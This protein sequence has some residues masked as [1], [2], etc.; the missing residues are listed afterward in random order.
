MGLRAD[1]HFC[2]NCGATLEDQPGFD[3]AEGLWR[4]TS[5]GQELYGDDFPEGTRFP[6]TIWRCDNCRAVLNT[7]YGFDDEEDEWECTECGHVNHLSEDEIYESEEDWEAHRRAERIGSFVG[8]MFS[9][10]VAGSSS[11]RDDASDDED[12][13]DDE[14][15]EDEDDEYDEDNDYGSYESAGNG[16]EDYSRY[17]SGSGDGRTTLSYLSRW[18]RLKLY[19]RIG[20]ACLSVLIAGLVFFGVTRAIPL[21]ISSEAA[22]G[23]QY[24]ELTDVLKM[25]GF[26]QVEAV[27][28]DDLSFEHLNE[29]G[30]VARVQLLWG[31]SFRDST[32]YPS[33]LPITVSYH[34]AKK[35]EA[36]LSSR[37]A[38][39]MNYGDVA[40][41]FQTAGFSVVRSEGKGDIIFGVL[42]KPDTV[43][44]VSIGGDKKFDA[45]EPYRVDAEVIITYHSKS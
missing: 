36:P 38:K 20:V 30:S 15:D 5:C 12:D 24:G 11:N 37:E 14:Y 39:G 17:Y 34:T 19:L 45:G 44:S 32:K 9:A 28:M 6:G 33:W 29:E 2:P 22:V 13:S 42:S 23:R 7:Q 27:A 21:G 4:C 26:S 1:E 25:N 40:A 16:T 10:F 43:D 35:V 41:A 3:P 31:S 18:D 8:D